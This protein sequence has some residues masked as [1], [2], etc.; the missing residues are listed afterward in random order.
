MFSEYEVAL[1]RGYDDVKSQIE[2]LAGVGNENSAQ[3]MGTAFE[4]WIMR[5][6]LPD[7]AISNGYEIIWP[8]G[9]SSQFEAI[10]EKGGER[11]LDVGLIIRKPGGENAADEYRAFIG[12]CVRPEDPENR[13]NRVKMQE[14]EDAIVKL[15]WKTGNALRQEFMDKLDE[16]GIIEDSGDSHEEHGT[17]YSVNRDKIDGF[18]FCFGHLCDSNAEGADSETRANLETM[19]HRFIDGKDLSKWQYL[20][21]PAN[22]MMNRPEQLQLGFRSITEEIDGVRLGIISAGSLYEFFTEN[23]QESP[24]FE[25]KNQSLLYK[26]LRYQL[27]ETGSIGDDRDDIGGTMKTTL[28]DEPGSFGQYNNGIVIV[29]RSIESLPSEE[30]IC[31]ACQN[32]LDNNQDRPD[33]CDDC[34]TTYPLLLELPNIVNGGQTTNAIWEWIKN[35]YHE[36]EGHHPAYHDATLSVKVIPCDNDEEITKIA[37][38]A[39][40]QNPIHPRDEYAL[41]EDQ[42]RYFE[43]FKEKGIVFD[44]KRGVKGPLLPRKAD[45]ELSHNSKTWKEM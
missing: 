3:A 8:S 9:N 12:Q 13:P 24:Y 1:K 37:R 38:Y 44:Y 36:T 40:R 6:W 45:F 25:G 10:G 34:S 2:A 26:N 31:Q 41:D 17:R 39:N 35:N 15:C 21:D 5:N 18:F 30:N 7:H 32:L 29:A 33:N 11:Q 23:R 43:F 16:V 27:P 28:R 4:K 19:G 14:V 22:A 42:E 20:K